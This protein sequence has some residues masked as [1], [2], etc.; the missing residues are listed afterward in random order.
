MEN[1]YSTENS[2]SIRYGNNEEVLYDETTTIHHL[3]I[4]LDNVN[5]S[6]FEVDNDSGEEFEIIINPRESLDQH[7][8]QDYTNKEF[9]KKVN[10]LIL[11]F[12][13]S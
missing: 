12:D 5:I 3:A 2:F 13:L 11:N 6:N 4:Q 7:R 1:D 8:Y 9:N 10:F